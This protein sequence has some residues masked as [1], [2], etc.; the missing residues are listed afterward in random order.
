MRLRLRTALLLTPLVIT[1]AGCFQQAGNALQ[2]TG[3][4]VEPLLPGDE[5]PATATE[6]SNLPSIPTQETIDNQ[7]NNSSVDSQL[8]TPTLPIAITIISPTR[9][10]AAT[11]TSAPNIPTAASDSSGGDAQFVTPLSPLGPVTP[12]TGAIS[13][14]VPGVEATSTPSGLI[15]PTALAGAESAGSCTHT[16]QP[17][18]N[19][20]RIAIRYEISVQELR[21]ANPDISGDLI[22]PGQV[23]AIPNCGIDT[24]GETEN[25][26]STITASTVTAPD[27]GQVYIV[28]RGDTLYTIGLQFGVTIAALQQANNLQNPNQLAV[29]QELIIPPPSP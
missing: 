10:P 22:Q 16:V 19:L 13:T 12:N 2:Q 28:Q 8:A 23:L 21:T 1:L 29:G 7:T 24:N 18:E 27:G 20:Y 6:D 9:G 17:G 11:A 5:T 4:T 25:T 26:P 3:S 15:T 14:S